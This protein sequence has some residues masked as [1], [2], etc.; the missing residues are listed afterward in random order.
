MYADDPSAGG[1]INVRFL[2]NTQ[3][4]LAGEDNILAYCWSTSF[5]GAGL[6]NA[7]VFGPCLFDWTGETYWRS[8]RAG[9]TG[10]GEGVWPNPP[11]VTTWGADTWAV[12]ESTWPDLAPR[13]I[14][15]HNGQ[16]H[17]PGP[18]QKS[19][20]ACVGIISGT[21]CDCLSSQ[22]RLTGSEP[23]GQEQSNWCWA[24][25]VQFVIRHLNC[26]E[27]S[28]CQ[29][30]KWGLDT[31]DCPNQGGLYWHVHRALETNEIQ[32]SDYDMFF[33]GD[34][35]DVF[36]R[37]REEIDSNRPILVG[38]RWAGSSSMSRPF[39]V[40]HM[41]VVRGYKYDCRTNNRVIEYYNIQLDAPPLRESSLLDEFFD[42]PRFSIVDVTYVLN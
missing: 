6:G 24:A 37:I 12:R 30:V 16:G 21:P 14:R 25:A 29:V 13:A 11:N 42:H 32:I 17:E 9:F 8:E 35:D 15:V 22:E 34:E 28:Q 3:Y 20:F 7:G 36:E 1:D 38:V 4:F 23:N 27:H 39:G 19:W 5:G 31:D 18:G 10:P 41:L 2:D 40:F 33:L 26:V